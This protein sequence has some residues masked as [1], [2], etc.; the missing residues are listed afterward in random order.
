MDT[1]LEWIGTL[2][3]LGILLVIIPAVFMLIITLQFRLIRHSRA[4]DREYVPGPRAHSH[5][6]DAR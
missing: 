1:L 6:E 2:L 3:L 4:P 5:G